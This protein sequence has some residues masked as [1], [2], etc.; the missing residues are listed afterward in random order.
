MTSK[1]KQAAPAVVVDT[2]RHDKIQEDWNNREYVDVVV[3]S[4][5][6]LSKFLNVF[7]Q[8][9][10]YRLAVLG[11]KMETLER[12]LDFVEARVEMKKRTSDANPT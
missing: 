9:C 7:D 5:K 3:T 10:R 2:S 6:K 11:E 4:M 1:K 12:K 8:S